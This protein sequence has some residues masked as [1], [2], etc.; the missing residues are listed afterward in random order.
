MKGAKGGKRDQIV[1]KMFHDMMEQIQ[2]EEGYVEKEDSSIL[3]EGTILEDSPIHKEAKEKSLENEEDITSPLTEQEMVSSEPKKLDSEKEERKQTEE[4][5]EVEEKKDKEEIEKEKEE[6]QILINEQSVEKSQEEIEEEPLEEEKVEVEKIEEVSLEETEDDITYEEM[7]LLYEMEKNIR[8]DYYELRDLE[9]RIDILSVKEEQVVLKEDIDAL[10]KELEELLKKF[11]LLKEKYEDWD[12]VESYEGVDKNYIRKLIEDYKEGYKSNVEIENLIQRIEETQKNIGIIE[13]I[14]ITE[15]KKDDIEEEIEDKYEAFE[16]RDKEFEELEKEVNDVEK[17]QLDIDKMSSNIESTLKDL[18]VYLKDAVHIT[19]TLE[20]RTERVFR[21]DRVVDA[22]TMLAMAASIPRSPL[23]N[24][25][26]ASMMANAIH[27][28]ANLYENRE[29]IT[30]RKTVSYT[31]YGK[32]I[33]N[34][35]SKLDGIHTEIDLALKEIKNIRETI[36]NELKD[37]I[38]LIPEYKEL[39]GKLDVIE[40]QLIEQQYNVEK[41]KEESKK[42]YLKNDEKRYIKEYEFREN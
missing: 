21:L 3:E 10:Q 42:Q 13:T 14:I 35:S 33:L 30:H 22:I 5:E 39:V 8:E 6:E 34:T 1:S 20:Q 26:R 19:N 28:F 40:D 12:I 31:D 36:E 32:E 37:Y 41:Y 7:L 17:I 16:I 2:K 9:Y 4:I 27:N 15:H 18:D 25:V 23:G 11:D 24:V 29:T 38:D